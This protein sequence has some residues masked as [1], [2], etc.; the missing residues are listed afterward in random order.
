[1][2]VIPIEQ[3]ARYALTSDPQSASPS[4]TD[5]CLLVSEVEGR[6]QSLYPCLVVGGTTPSVLYEDNEPA[7]N[8]YNRMVGYL[9]AARLLPGRSGQKFQATSIVVKV[10][11]VTKTYGGPINVSTQVHDLSS[12]AAEAAQ[13]VPCIA[14]SIAAASSA[15]GNLGCGLAGYRRARG[16]TCTLE[17]ALLGV[18]EVPF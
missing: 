5:L 2:A 1:M 9:V 17:E 16:G 8:A 7:L 3:W 11:P 14:A 18:G 10:G 12:R 6:V 4:D 13:L 15:R